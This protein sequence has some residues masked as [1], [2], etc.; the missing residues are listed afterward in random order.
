MASSNRDV[1]L[2]I[3]AKDETGPGLRSAQ[4]AL[5]RLAAAQ[6]RTQARRDQYAGAKES[7]QSLRKAYDDAA[8]T[9]EKLG[10]RMGAASRPSK[11]L[12]DEFAASREAARA[13]KVEY[14]AAEKALGKLQGRTGRTGG[15]AKFDDY[16]RTL[17]PV[18][19]ITNVANVA[20][21]T[22]RGNRLGLAPHQM[23]NLGYQVNDIVSGLAMGQKPMMI[24]AQQGGQ[25]AQIFPAAT[26]AILRFIPVVGLAAVA[27]SPFIANMVKANNEA[28]RL[29]D[30]EAILQRSGNAAQY[31]A[32][33]LAEFAKRLED[34]GVKGKDVTAILS[35]FV[36]DAVDPT[37]LEPFAQAAKGL[38]AAMGTDLAAASEKVSGA[39]TG[40]AEAVLALDDE[41]RFLTASERKHIEALK[42]SGKEAEARTTAFDIFAKRYGTVAADMDGP[43]TSAV[44][45]LTS[46]WE[47]F[48]DFVNFIDWS[49]VKSEINGLIGLVDDLTSKLG[50]A[51]TRTQAATL[52]T[53]FGKEQEL[54]RERAR[55]SEA[56]RRGER[57]NAN[58]R[59]LDI[60]RLEKEVAT[61]RARGREQAQ[62]QTT[63]A[64][65]RSS[66]TTSR[67]DA[68]ATART[69]RGGS[70]K[71]ESDRRAEA[72]SKF[73]AML[74]EE[75]ETRRFQLSLMDEIERQQ[76]VLTNLRQAEARAQEVGLQL[77]EAQ[78]QAIADTT[79]ALYDRAKA[80]EAGKAIEQARL[81]LAQARGKVLTREAFIAQQ[82]ARSNLILNDQQRETL[83][84]I[85]GDLHDIDAAARQRQD[86][87]KGVNDL[88]ALRRELMAA[89]ELA[90][91]SGDQTRVA[92]LQA[93]IALLNQDLIAAARHALTLMANLSGPE[94]EAARQAM[95]NLIGET[96]RFGN[97]AVTTPEEIN[98]SLAN[99][100][101]N[102]L[103]RFAE[104]VVEGANA[105]D[106]LRDSFMQFAADF[107]REIAFMIAQ[108]ALF[109]ALDG[110]TGGVG[111]K[112]SGFVNG[113]FGSK[114][115]GGLV[116]H[117]GGL[118]SVSP[119]VFAGATR[120][121]SGGLIGLAPNEVPIIAMRNEEVLT[122]DD[123]R[124]RNNG[125]LSG[126]SITAKIV[127]MID[128]GDMLSQGL[129]TEA[130]EQSI[131]NF[132]GRNAGALKARLG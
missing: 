70:G 77:T 103:D 54:A 21:A 60:I 95:S 22:P 125:G 126:K 121:H 50:G 37:Y 49:K 122:E 123:P 61:L 71:S 85:L 75:N 52:D 97:K 101:A 65:S 41:L 111:G 82:M 90:A 16:A 20:P 35:T 40:N 131:M 26:G 29:T 24:L 63:P 117:G 55:L 98:R 64:P 10:Q 14:L 23:T 87:E 56:E 68:P 46:A 38:A 106:A 78:R 79:T 30:A 84:Q 80:D 11:K 124:H 66:D 93:R 51:R 25:I 17:T 73:L 129:E 15:F 81:E 3:R 13:A 113:L 57:G 92:E 130:G 112:V 36:R 42:A 86:A 114:H 107:L 48:V 1:S 118:R 6:K 67:P 83:G 96:E 69:P 7:A 59:R 53:L 105:F 109:A 76:Q 91:E 43:W 18:P 44:K 128:S 2:R 89:I 108:K 34:I 19:K 72:Q 62:Q 119:A 132:I 47:G 31:S 32:P 115:T 94:A 45:N 120:Y 88:L 27:L 39:F 4:S 12:R 127:N 116:G 99:G 102:A 100:G 104:S 110:A 9:A 28:R 33:Q 8:T 5:D 58:N 74:A